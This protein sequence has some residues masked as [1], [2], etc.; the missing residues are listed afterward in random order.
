[1]VRNEETMSWQVYSGD[2]SPWLSHGP[3]HKRDLD[4]CIKHPIMWAEAE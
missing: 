3:P 1:M 4:D 2:G